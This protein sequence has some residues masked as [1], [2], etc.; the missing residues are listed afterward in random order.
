MTG[1]VRVILGWH[2]DAKEKHAWS[3]SVTD[4]NVKIF[5]WIDEENLE[6][7]PDESGARDEPQKAEES[8]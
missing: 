3:Y 6:L 8:K 7:L 1:E 5:E 2:Y 4:E